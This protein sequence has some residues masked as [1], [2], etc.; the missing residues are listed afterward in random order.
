L[1][2]LLAPLSI[3][4]AMSVKLQQWDNFTYQFQKIKLTHEYTFATFFGDDYGSCVPQQKQVVRHAAVTLKAKP[5]FRRMLHDEAN[6]SNNLGRNERPK[7]SKSNEN[8]EENHPTYSNV[9]TWRSMLC[10]LL[11]YG[12][13]RA[14]RRRTG[15]NMNHA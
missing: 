9:G 6:S 4:A 11:L 14:R 8:R 13:R 1:F 7:Q 2:L 3:A 5:L 15:C 12:C 10:I